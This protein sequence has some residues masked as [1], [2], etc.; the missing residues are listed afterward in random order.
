MRTVAEYPRDM[1]QIQM[2]RMGLQ[3][4][5]LRVLVSTGGSASSSRAAADVDAEAGALPFYSY[6]LVPV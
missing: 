4:S 3:T 2:V 1:L 5:I 6:S